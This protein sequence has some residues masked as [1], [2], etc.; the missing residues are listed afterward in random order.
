MANEDEE[1]SVFCLMSFSSAETQSWGIPWPE[2]TPARKP[3][4]ALTEIPHVA[5][6]IVK[7]IF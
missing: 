1:D 2:I 4:L 6:S 3:F 5:D 7:Y